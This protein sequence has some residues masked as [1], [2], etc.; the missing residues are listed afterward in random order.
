MNR[1]N[2]IAKRPRLK[3]SGPKSLSPCCAVARPGADFYN[4]GRPA[5]RKVKTCTSE[6]NPLLLSDTVYKTAFV[7][8]NSV[9]ANSP[10]IREIED[11]KVWIRH[12][13]CRRG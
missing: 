10:M 3:K 5:F 12:Y 7:Y 9:I 11:G 8:I 2:A 4:C 1:Q 6:L 13:I